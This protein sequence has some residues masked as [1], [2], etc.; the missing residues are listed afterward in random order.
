MLGA[1]SSRPLSERNGCVGSA[2]LTVV[3]DA[4]AVIAVLNH[5]H[6]HHE[7]AVALFA[8]FDDWLIHPVTLA[9]VL[10]HPARLGRD[11]AQAVMLDLVEV[12]MVVRQS[13]IDPL[14]LA[15]FRA[16]TRLKMPDC[17][18]LALA[19]EVGATHVLTFDDRLGVISAVRL[20]R[21]P[22]V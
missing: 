19:V 15:E 21:S 18:V 22:V 16:A 20:F 9:E 17:L 11:V 2:R 3:A 10:V 12:G 5:D 6:V 4:S 7:Q 8:D 1:P 13:M 14:E